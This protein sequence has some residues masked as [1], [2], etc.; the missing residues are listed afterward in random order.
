M[1]LALRVV[2][3]G[4]PGTMRHRACAPPM[5]L[6]QGVRRAVVIGLISA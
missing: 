1:A 2:N 3:M 6:R 5:A 4:R